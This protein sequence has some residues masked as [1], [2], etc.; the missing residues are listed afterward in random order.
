MLT[1]KKSSE[2]MASTA[3]H[4]KVP[5]LDLTEDEIRDLQRKLAEIDKEASTVL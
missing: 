1:F 2:K 3:G 4:M 5:Q